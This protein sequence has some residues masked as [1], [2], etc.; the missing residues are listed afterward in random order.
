MGTGFVCAGPPRGLRP[1][2]AD[3]GAV[4]RRCQV[5]A[6]GRSHAFIVVHRLDNLR[7]SGRIGGAKA[8][9]WHGGLALK[10]LLRIDDGK[11]V[12]AQTSSHHQ[13]RD[14]RR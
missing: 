2:A 10:P 4:R 7:R 6:V 3:L 5:P 8:W 9:A 11:L 13:Q 14:V 12:L 1:R